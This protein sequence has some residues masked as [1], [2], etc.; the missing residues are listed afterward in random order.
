MDHFEE[1]R[2]HLNR[3]GRALSERAARASHDTLDAEHREATRF[4]KGDAVVDSVTGLEGT[5]ERSAFQN[6]I[7]PA[8]ERADG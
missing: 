1:A 7:V 4:R 6:Y 2:E 3:V 8:P 5:V